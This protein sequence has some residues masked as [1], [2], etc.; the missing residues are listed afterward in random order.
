MFWKPIKG[1]NSKS[2]KPLAPIPVTRY[3]QS[4]SVFIRTFSFL[5]FII[6]EKSVKKI[7]KN[8]KIWKPIKGHK[9]KR[10]GSLA[11]IL[12]LRLPYFRDHVRYKFHLSRITNIKVIEQNAF[13]FFENLTRDII[14]S[15]MDPWALFWYTLY[16]QSLSMFIQIFSFLAFMTPEKSVTKIFKNGKIW[17]PMKWYN[18]KSYGPLATILPLHLLYL[19]DQVWYKFHWSRITNIKVTEQTAF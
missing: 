5:A 3:I 7:L 16:I 13:K 9:P 11:T 6:S 15:V 19:R 1:H 17:K 2:Y 12:P 14:P 4:L 18:S 10:Y 8:G